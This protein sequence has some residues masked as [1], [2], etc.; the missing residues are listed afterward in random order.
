MQK[1]IF[2]LLGKRKKVKGKDFEFLY[3]FPLPLIPRGGP[4]FPSTPT[5]AISLLITGDMTTVLAVLQQGLNSKE[6]AR[7]CSGFNLAKLKNNVLKNT[8]Y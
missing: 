8:N 5:F 7:V 2:A 1:Y 4:T 6:H 3:P